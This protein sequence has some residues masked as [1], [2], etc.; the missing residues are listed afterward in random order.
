MTSQERF[1]QC[2]IHSTALIEDG[3]M[4]GEGTAIWDNVHI[5]AGARVGRHCIVGEKTYLAYDVSVGDFCKL[6]SGVYVCAGVRIADHVMLAAHVVFTNDKFP[7]AFDRQLGELATSAP[8]EKTLATTVERGVT[9]GANATIG[10]GLRLGEFCM[11]GMGCVVTRE[12][13]AH[14][15]IVGNPGRLEGFVCTCGPIL[16]RR[17][18]WEHE[19]IGT[20][21]TCKQCGRMYH[22]TAT[23]IVEA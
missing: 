6:N 20:K 19:T 9:V 23:G 14:G 11:A 10:P 7:R 3:V 15:L 16:V 21:Y 22:R 17:D 2:R 12:I 13:P 18:D 5:R 8:T 4:L 1:P